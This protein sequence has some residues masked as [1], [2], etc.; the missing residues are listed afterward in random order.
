[1]IVSDAQRYEVAEECLRRI[2]SL[3]RFDAD[4]K[5]MISSLPSYTQLGM[6]ALLPNRTLELAA[7]GDGTVLAD[8]AGANMR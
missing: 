4:L 8:G 6:D 5:P 3:N 1:M 7:D 2:R